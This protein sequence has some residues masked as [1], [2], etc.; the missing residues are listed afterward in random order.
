[1]L[2]LILLFLSLNIQAEVVVPDS[3]DS[4]DEFLDES[5]TPIDSSLFRE[6][7][8]IETHVKQGNDNYIPLALKNEKINLEKPPEKYKAILKK[9]STLTNVKTGQE[10]FID[11]DL[12]VIARQKFHGG[13]FS[14]IYN[15]KQKIS[16]KTKTKNLTSVENDII[17][18]PE[19]DAT[20]VNLKKT[21]FNT[22][23]S[24]LVLDNSLALGFLSFSSQPALETVGLIGNSA[25]GTSFFTRS[26]IKSSLPLRFGLEAQYLSAQATNEFNESTASWTS[27]YLGPVLKYPFYQSGKWA[28]S[29]LFSVKKSL[30]YSLTTNDNS[31]SF[32][33]VSWNLQ[34]EIER[35]F[36]YG[37]LAMGLGYFNEKTSIKPQVE[38]NINISGNK[39]A[40][41]GLSV[42]VGYNFELN[43]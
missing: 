8:I 3:S 23:D 42:T 31:Y 37:S 19:V 12:Y 5:P 28:M 32:S 17:I 43:L 38:D 9:G 13:Q 20:I 21:S 15:K 33:S 16:Y 7:D 26:L 34:F 41:N 14:Y 29:S 36:T 4:L 40:A 6:V 35:Q 10:F 25:T 18:H 39:T 30:L 24:T 2:K 22:T 11:K 27:F 1:L